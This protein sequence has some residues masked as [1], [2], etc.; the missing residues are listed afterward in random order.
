MSLNSI[1]IAPVNGSKPKYL[2]VGLHGWGSN[3][4]DLAA[5]V[6]SLNLPDCQFIFP[7]AP[8]AHPQVPGGKAWYALE[9]RSYRGLS[10]SR[11][12]LRG[13]LQSLAATTA[14][15]LSQT[16]LVGFSQGGAM[17]LDVGLNLPLAGLC[18]LSGYLHSSISVAEAADRPP[19]L[20]VHGERDLVVPIQAAIAARERLTEMGVTVEYQEFAMGHEI[21]PAAIA[22]LEKFIFARSLG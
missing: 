20:I 1:V 6:P 4:E 5:L 2:L 13:F 16:I 19:V 22:L 12:T 11:D 14:I 7:N 10:E 18:S 21:I 3:A 9:D 17:T 8:F 15:P